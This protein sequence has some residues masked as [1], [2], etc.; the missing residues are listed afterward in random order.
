VNNIGDG[1]LSGVGAASNLAGNLPALSGVFAAASANFSLADHGTQTFQAVF[2]PTS[3][4]LAQNAFNVSTTNGSADGT[5][6]SQTLPVTF[7]GTGVGPAYGSLIAPSSPID[8]GD[9]LGSSGRRVLSIANA[10]AS[11]DLGALTDLKLLSYSFSGPNADEFSL[12]NFTPGQLLVKGGS[13][14]LQIDFTSAGTIGTHT[15]SLTLVTDQNAASGAN[16]LSFSYPLLV[17]AVPE[18]GSLALLI[19]AFGSLGLTIMW[20][21]R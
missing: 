19:A 7:S 11:A 3:P 8:F 21:K 13:F 17:N 20:R 9:V 10:T 6:K 12:P 5:N 1:N 14:D 18:P 4:G 2:T 15:A 16:G